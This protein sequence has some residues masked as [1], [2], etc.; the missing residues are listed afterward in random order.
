MSNKCE[1]IHAFLNNLTRFV[2]PYDENYL[3][4]NGIY[5]QFEKNEF[6]HSYDRIVRIGTHDGQNNL[7]QRIFEHFKIEGIRS[8]FRR[9]IRCAIVNQNIKSGFSNWTQEDL[10]D[11]GISKIG[12][13]KRRLQA[14]GKWKEIDE[15]LSEYIIDNVSFACIE[16]NNHRDRKLFESRLISTISNCSECKNTDKWLGIYS[17][18]EKVRYSGLWQEKELW[19]DDFS[20]FEFE[21]FIKILE[22]S[23]K[24]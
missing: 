20:D 7:K 22:I 1:Q 15:I 13:A 23:R 19:K 16:V 8:V 4:K 11:C 12:E 5:V 6:A 17:T 2:Y 3:P 10:K 9:K 18:T 21:N 14:K 24:M